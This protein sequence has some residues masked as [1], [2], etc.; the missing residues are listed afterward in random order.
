MWY[1]LVRGA[2]FL[3]VTPWDLADQPMTWLL[4]AELAQSAEAAAQK[5]AQAKQRGSHRGAS[6]QR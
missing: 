4:Q 6:R 3:G 2:K 5:A 1:R